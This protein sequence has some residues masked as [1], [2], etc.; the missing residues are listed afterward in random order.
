MR[1]RF[2]TIPSQQFIQGKDKDCRY[3]L[4]SEHSFDAAH[5]LSGHCGLCKNLHGHNWRVE[6]KL[7]SNKLIEEGTSRDMVCDFK[8]LKR[9]FRELVDNFDHALIAEEN[10]ISDNLL[11]A[12]IQEGFE[13]IRLVPFRPTCENFAPFFFYEMVAKGYDVEC[14]KVWET[15]INS[16]EYREN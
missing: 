11:N 16:C 6:I 10:T 5:W 15:E 9:D 14:I 13:R 4:V 1:E 2:K 12:L 7:K 8:D 3:S